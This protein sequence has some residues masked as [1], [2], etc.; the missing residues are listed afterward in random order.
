MEDKQGGSEVKAL[1]GKRE[2]PGSTQNPWGKMS[3]PL[4]GAAAQAPAH[5]THQ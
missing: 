1:L 5:N 3:R 4:Y 2:Y